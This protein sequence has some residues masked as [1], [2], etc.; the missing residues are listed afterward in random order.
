MYGS[1]F[2]KHYV[3]LLDHPLITKLLKHVFTYFHWSQKMHRLKNIPVPGSVTVSST[4]HAQALIGSKY[5]RLCPY[6]IM[7]CDYECSSKWR[8]LDL[9]IRNGISESQI[10]TSRDYCISYRKVQR[11]FLLDFPYRA[12]LSLCRWNNAE[13]GMRSISQN[14]CKHLYNFFFLK[15]TA[16]I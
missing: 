3:D 16:I 2:L 9:A 12:F 13:D 6:E 10:A 14:F 1:Y 5:L 4:V 7:E 11:V 15:S 8:E